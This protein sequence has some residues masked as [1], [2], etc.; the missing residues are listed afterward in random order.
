MQLT[1][2]KTAILAMILIAVFAIG[3]FAGVQFGPK[4]IY[5]TVEEAISIAPDSVAITMKPNE[6]MLAE[7]NITNIASNPI[8]LTIN[9]GCLNTT[10]A[11]YFTL[12]YESPFSA[13]P[14]THPY[15]VSIY[16]NASTPIG[17]YVFEVTWER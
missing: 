6:T 13:E 5:V 2:K 8:S 10:E 3:V 12:D 14:G 16:A 9:V 7:F 17:T 11:G 4:T 15:T 1:K